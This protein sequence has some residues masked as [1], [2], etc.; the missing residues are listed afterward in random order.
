MRAGV[1]ACTRVHA[2]CSA[3]AAPFHSND[4]LRPSLCVHSR[5]VLLTNLLR[6][7][8]SGRWF[9]RALARSAYIPRLLLYFT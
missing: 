6:G 5:A 9:V 4:T 7:I 8:I 2:P 1:C 3:S